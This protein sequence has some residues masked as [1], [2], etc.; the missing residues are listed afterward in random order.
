M[1]AQGHS[2]P[3]RD[4]SGTGDVRYVPNGRH[5]LHSMTSLA[6]ARNVKAKR[7]C[8]PVRE[9]AGGL[10]H[11][12]NKIYEHRSP[13]FRLAR[14]QIAKNQEGTAGTCLISCDLARRANRASPPCANC[15][16]RYSA[17]AACRCGTRPTQLTLTPSRARKE[18]RFAVVTNVGCG[19]RWTLWRRA[20]ERRQRGRRSRVVL[21]PRRWRQVLEKQASQG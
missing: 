8:L 7:F 9:P 18:G 11:R 17:A 19:M 14:S 12:S 1:S 20:D 16:S 13:N 10:F 2:R 5:C 15:P 4:S 3:G 21:T 6:L